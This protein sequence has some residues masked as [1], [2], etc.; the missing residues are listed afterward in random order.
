[1]LARRFNGG[2]RNMQPNRAK[3]GGKTKQKGQRA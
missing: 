2:R 3:E 1:L